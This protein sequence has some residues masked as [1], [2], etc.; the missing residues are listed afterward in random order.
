MSI[1]RKILVVLFAVFIIIQV[2]RPE[3]NQSAA[4]TPND[5]FAHY[6]ADANTKQLIQTACYDCHSNNTVFHGMQKY[7]LL[8]G[9][10]PIMLMKGSL[11]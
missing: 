10:L 7:S 6:K 4:E 11:N 1:S 5:I 2:F 3:K 9:G 8:P